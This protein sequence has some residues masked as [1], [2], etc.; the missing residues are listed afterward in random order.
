M[1]AGPMGAVMAEEALWSAV[2]ADPGDLSGNASGDEGVL[3]LASSAQLAGLTSLGLGDNDISDQA[4]ASLMSCAH[5]ARLTR[6]DLGGNRVGDRFAR[7]AGA[8]RRPGEAVISRPRPPHRP[9]A[10][11]RRPRP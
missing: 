5:L 3:A 2:L 11:G 8:V 6:L 4:A 10:A 9:A 1:S 7:A